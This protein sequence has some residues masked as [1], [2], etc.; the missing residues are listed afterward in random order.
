MTCNLFASNYKNLLRLGY[1]GFC[2]PTFISRAAETTLLV[3]V[4]QTQD[5]A[6][7]LFE[8]RS[9][10]VREEMCL[11]SFQ[12][13]NNRCFKKIARAAFETLI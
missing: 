13:Q 7:R 12:K 8:G 1:L 9:E 10:G 3:V 4:S 5:Q 11:M 2:G 6:G